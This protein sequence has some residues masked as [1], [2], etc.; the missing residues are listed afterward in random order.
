MVIVNYRLSVLYSAGC[1]QTLLCLSDD[2]AASVH[3]DHREAA[4]K[5]VRE[6]WWL[7]DA[8]LR[9]HTVPR[10]ALLPGSIALAP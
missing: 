7:H 5:I 3:P 4:S 8:E 2:R 6:S 9:T 10:A 1:N